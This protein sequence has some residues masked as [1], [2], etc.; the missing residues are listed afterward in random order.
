M[1]EGILYGGSTRSTRR[2]TARTLQPGLH[3]L[4]RMQRQG[5]DQ[6]PG[7]AC[8]RMLPAQH[9]VAVAT[10]GGGGA[11]SASAAAPHSDNVCNAAMS[12]RTTAHPFAPFASFR[13]VAL[14]G[15]HSRGF[16]SPRGLPHNSNTASCRVNVV[17]GRHRDVGGGTT[18]SPPAQFGVALSAKIGRTWC[19]VL[20]AST[21]ERTSRAGEASTETGASST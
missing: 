18:S 12:L 8:K 4:Q 9:S 14:G 3:Q 21:G 16:D 17:V 6:T 7:G 5:S 2:G 13:E 19:K 1:P 20:G 11:A 10:G 15:Q